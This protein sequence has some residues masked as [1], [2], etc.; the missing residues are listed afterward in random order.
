MRH[1]RYAFEQA[2][3]PWST[4][5]RWGLGTTI[6]VLLLM[7]VVASVVGAWQDRRQPSNQSIPI[8]F[9]Q[10]QYLTGALSIAFV[11]YHIGHV[12]WPQWRGRL[13]HEQVYPML[14]RSLSSTAAGVPVSAW[15]YTFGLFLVLYHW[16]YGVFAWVLREQ[17]L[18]ASISRRQWVLCVASFGILLF[19]IGTHTLLF[20]GTGKG[21]WL[22]MVFFTNPP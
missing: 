4:A 3:V 10:I 7:H 2:S 18:P 1:G 17:W 22:G 19:G 6:V 14:V 11:G 20:L 12:S 5:T 21:W 13:G 16:L 9:Q 15:L 8:I